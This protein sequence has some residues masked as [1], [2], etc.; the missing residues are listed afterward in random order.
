[1]RAVRAAQ[2]QSDDGRRNGV[3]GVAQHSRIR[4]QAVRPRRRSVMGG[5]R[6]RLVFHDA[7]MGLRQQSVQ[8]QRGRSLTASPNRREAGLQPLVIL[9]RVAIDR[10]DVRLDLL[11]RDLAAKRFGQLA[12]ADIH[13]AG[14]DRGDALCGEDDGGSRPP[15]ASR[16]ENRTVAQRG[17]S[18]DE[19]AQDDRPS[20]AAGRR[21]P[22]SRRR[23][24]RARRRR[25]R[26]PRVAPSSRTC[27]DEISCR[28]LST[29]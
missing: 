12:A 22:P 5:K 7:D 17:E 2:V 24:A 19:G 21:A 26:G 3:R 8:I 10:V 20:P 4:V 9:T 11:G 18:R 15:L 29:V 13:G 23:R 6:L 1:M 28:R 27:K 16:R 14:G 25:R